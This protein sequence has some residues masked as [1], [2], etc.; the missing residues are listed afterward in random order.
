MNRK[1]DLP[2]RKAIVLGK[3]NLPNRDGPF[4][5]K[6]KGERTRDKKAG[7]RGSGRERELRPGVERVV[8]QQRVLEGRIGAG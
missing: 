2:R 7:G 8:D 6:S 1:S 5:G 3:R 4:A